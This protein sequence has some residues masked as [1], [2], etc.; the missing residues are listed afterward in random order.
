MRE[1]GWMGWPG[2]ES[3]DVRVIQPVT[4]TTFLTLLFPILH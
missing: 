3:N 1:R 2:R 4:L